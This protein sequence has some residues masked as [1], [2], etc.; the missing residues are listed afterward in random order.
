MNNIHKYLEIKLI[1]EENN[2]IT[3]LELSINRNYNVLHLG[4]HR[5]P[6]Q[7]YTTIHFLSNHPLEHKLAAYNF[8]I[9]RRIALAIRE[10]AN[11]Q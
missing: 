11:Q 7:T 4:I 2:N 6:K 10:Q 9:N 1:E 5:K 8:Y 3:Y